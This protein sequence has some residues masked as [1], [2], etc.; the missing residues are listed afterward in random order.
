MAEKLQASLGVEEFSN[1]CVQSQVSGYVLIALMLHQCNFRVKHKSN[2][3]TVL[4]I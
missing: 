2:I 1:L 4:S 3:F